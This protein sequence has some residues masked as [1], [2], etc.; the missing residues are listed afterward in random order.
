LNE[1]QAGRRSLAN[2]LESGGTKDLPNQYYEYHILFT[3]SMLKANL[4]TIPYALKVEPRRL[5]PMVL[6]HA[7]K[8]EHSEAYST[9]L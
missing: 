7:L 3:S 2:N 1:N 4:Y 5:K 9:A 8:G 6:P